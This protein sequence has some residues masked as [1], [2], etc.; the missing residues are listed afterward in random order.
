MNTN[1]FL[2]S[3]EIKIK[4]LAIDSSYHRGAV[5]ICLSQTDFC[6][7]FSSGGYTQGYTLTGST[8]YDC[9]LCDKLGAT[10]AGRDDPYLCNCGMLNPSIIGLLS[11][12]EISYGSCNYLGTI[13][14]VYICCPNVAGDVVAVVL[15]VWG[16]T[17]AGTF[18]LAIT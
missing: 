5:N 15:C 10:R 17:A 13:S 4:Y 8:G 7:V 14:R 12:R 3:Y 18:N 11:S 9:L 16:L 6:M 2:K 1:C